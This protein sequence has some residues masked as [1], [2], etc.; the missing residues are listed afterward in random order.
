MRSR[1]EYP[2]DWP[3]IA[4]RIKQKN[5]W[6]CERCG[7]AHDPEAGYTL[8]VHHLIADKSLC[9]NWN[10]AALCQRCHLSIQARINMF[11]K[12]FEFV[13]IADWFKP[14][15]DGFQAWQRRGW[16]DMLEVLE[17]KIAPN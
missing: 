17:E 3:E 2:E 16:Q 9:E 11:Q 15:L 8:T 4:E 12:I 14:H 6:K 13:D 5:G 1:G 7:H 10:L